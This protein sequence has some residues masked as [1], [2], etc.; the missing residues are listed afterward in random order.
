MM[1]D[2]KATTGLP[3]FRAASTSLDNWKDFMT[4]G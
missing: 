2:S 1:V 3:E 4:L